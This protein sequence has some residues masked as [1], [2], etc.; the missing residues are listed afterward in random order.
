MTRYDL[1][2][3]KDH[4]GKITEPVGTMNQLRLPEISQR[5]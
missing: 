5:L 3:A 1:T 4:D 2:L